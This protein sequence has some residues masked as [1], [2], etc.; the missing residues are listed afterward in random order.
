M[1]FQ[2]IRVPDPMVRCGAINI[3][4]LWLRQARQLAQKSRLARAIG[5]AQQDQFPGLCGDRYISKQHAF[6][7]HSTEARTLDVKAVTQPS[8]P[9]FSV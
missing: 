5:A 9:W 2:T 1:R 7:A 3:S 8:Y 4:G 6:T